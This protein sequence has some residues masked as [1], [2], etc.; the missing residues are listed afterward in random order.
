MYVDL[1]QL[2]SVIFGSRSFIDATNVNLF[3]ISYKIVLYVY[4]PNLS[5]FETGALSFCNNT[6]FSLSSKLLSKHEQ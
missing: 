1:P 3:S 5:S 2:R 6:V 4:L